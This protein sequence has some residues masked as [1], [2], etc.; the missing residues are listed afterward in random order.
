MFKGASVRVAWPIF[1]SIGYGCV[2]SIE[3]PILGANSTSLFYIFQM[4]SGAYYNS[5]YKDN[6]TV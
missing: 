1:P 6:K 4:G 5:T 2:P 3:N